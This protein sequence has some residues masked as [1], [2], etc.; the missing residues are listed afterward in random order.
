MHTKKRL[1]TLLASISLALPQPSYPTGG[2]RFKGTIDVSGTCG[3]YPEELCSQ[4]FP[5]KNAT[6]RPNPTTCL[7]IEGTR[8]TSFPSQIQLAST[9]ESRRARAFLAGNGPVSVDLKI[10]YTWITAGAWTDDGELL[11]VDS[12]RGELV[13]LTA[14]GQIIPISLGAQ[15]PKVSDIRATDDGTMLKLQDGRF[16]ALDRQGRLRKILKILT[17]EEKMPGIHGV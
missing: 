15:A 6:G 5:I 4:T 14:S 1:M 10:P 17:P 7:A 8:K 13:R 3:G 12:G 16:V 9:T 2:S 11:L